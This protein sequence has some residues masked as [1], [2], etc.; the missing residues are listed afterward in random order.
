MNESQRQVYSQLISTMAEFERLV[1]I[2]PYGPYS[3]LRSRR[4]LRR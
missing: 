4:E 2:E 1:G 3:R